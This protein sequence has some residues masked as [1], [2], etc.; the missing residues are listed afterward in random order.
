MILS[1]KRIARKSAVVND[2]FR[3][4]RTEMLLG[5]IDMLRRTFYI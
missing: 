3:S 4:P 5:K 2:K 1:V